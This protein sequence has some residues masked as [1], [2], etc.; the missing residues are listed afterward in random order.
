M[1]ETYYGLTGRPFQLTPD[2]AFFFNSQVHLKAVSYLLYGLGQGEGFIVLTGEVGAGKT[3]LLRHLLSRLDAS[4]YVAATI[5]TSQLAADDLLRMVAL[6]FGIAPV[7]DKALLLAAIQ[8]FL[9]NNHRQGRRS[10]LLVDEAQNLP[11]SALEELR[12]L[13]NFQAEGKPLMQS[14]LVAQ[15]EFRLTIASSELEQLR[16]RVIASYHLGPM[17]LAETGTYIDHRLHTAGWREDPSFD[18][19]CIPVIYRHTG[20]VPRRI[21]TL[22]SRLLLFGCLEEKHK[23]TADMT[24]AVA[25]DLRGELSLPPQPDRPPSHPGQTDDALTQRLRQLDARSFRHDVALKRTLSV[26]ANLVAGY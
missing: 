5:E 4:R 11:V 16:Q 17:S 23:I 14:F 6:S 2:P 25:D 10:L 21:N 1:F 22:M 24:E 26:F 12:M 8:R 7:S 3:T 18:D 13:S 9:I 15:P 20:G 19:D